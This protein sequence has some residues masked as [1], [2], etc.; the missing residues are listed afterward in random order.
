[1]TD[2]QVVEN[3]SEDLKLSILKDEFPPE[4]VIIHF[5]EENLDMCYSANNVHGLATF[6][7]E[8]F[9]SKFLEFIA[10]I[11]SPELKI[12]DFDEAREIAKKKGFPIIAIH[13]LDDV[14]KPI[15]HYI[16]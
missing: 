5:P 6:S 16:A 12:V 11:P 3:V 4:L 2:T 10:E 14:N 13:L 9:A 7:S 15:T 1:M 8:P